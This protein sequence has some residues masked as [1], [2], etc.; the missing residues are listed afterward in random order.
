MCVNLN[1]NAVRRGVTYGYYE[2]HEIKKK[3]M[4]GVLLICFGRDLGRIDLGDFSTNG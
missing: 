3:K 1:L 4:G 2:V